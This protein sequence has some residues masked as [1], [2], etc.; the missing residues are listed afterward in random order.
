[1]EG[2]VDAIVGRSYIQH[3]FGMESSGLANQIMLSIS[4]N[5]HPSISIDARYE[6]IMES[7]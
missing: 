7:P 4:I 3:I 2:D 1:M 6:Q 5:S